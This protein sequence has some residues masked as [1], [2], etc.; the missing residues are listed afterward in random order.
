MS[1]LPEPTSEN[2]YR[3][4]TN[5]KNLQKFNDQ[6]YTYTITKCANCFLLLTLNDNE[7]PGLEIGLDLLSGAITGISV[8]E[9]GIIG[10]IAAE[11]ICG[12]IEEY[13][14]SKPPSLLMQFS[15]YITRI[16]QTSI[17]FD[18]D[19][20]LYHSDTE[21]YWTNMYSGTVDTPWGPKSYEGC[22]AQ[23]AEIDFPSEVDTLYMDMMKKAVYSFDQFIW[24]RIIKNN[25]YRNGWNSGY[26]LPP[27]VQASDL[28]NGD[29]SANNYS[30]NYMEEE[31]AHLMIWSYTHQ[32]DKKGRDTSYYVFYDYS[33]GWPPKNGND[34]P[35]S[36]DAAKYLFIDTIPGNIINADGLFN[37]YYVF[38]NFGL[39][40]N[41]F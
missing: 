1:S 41:G 14:T 7:D 28:P 23:L 9:F 29:T 34:R 3:V 39:E 26:L 17:Q 37:R 20:S 5:L 25:F 8:E 16:Q 21:T 18:S 36:D 24:W 27:I 2:I 4:R 33:L 22:L 13:A 12:R 19:L 35:I 40:Q 30:S 11:F 15:S 38:Y 32:T 31:P 6:L 10:H